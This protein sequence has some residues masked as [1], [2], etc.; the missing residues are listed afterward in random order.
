[1]KKTSVDLFNDN[2]RLETE[3]LTSKRK[4][5]HDER[6]ASIHLKKRKYEL[7]Y[8]STPNGTESPIP[9]MSTG[10]TVSAQDKEIEIL[11][12]KIR[13]AELTAVPSLLTAVPSLLT[14]VPSL[15]TAVPSLL[16]AVPS[17]LTDEQANWEGVY[18]FMDIIE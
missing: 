14:A 16:T 10:S 11:R 15:L 5:D 1:M 4:M 2:R 6:M 18:N 7:R 13:L 9:S 3:R 17:P 8:G 12:L